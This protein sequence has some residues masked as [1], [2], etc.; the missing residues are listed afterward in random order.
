M[1]VE[2]LVYFLGRPK[3]QKNAIV[4]RSNDHSRRRRKTPTIIPGLRVSGSGFRV[5]F[6]RFTGIGNARRRACIFPWAAQIQKN[7]IVAPSNDHSRRRRKTPTI[8][9]GLRV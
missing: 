1:P 6:L 2:R 7:A 4:S 3:F 9:P 8:I 5:R